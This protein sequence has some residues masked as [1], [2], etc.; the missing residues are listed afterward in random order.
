MR[1]FVTGA[2]DEVLAFAR[3]FGVTVEPAEPGDMMPHNLRTA[4]LDAEGR[5]VKTYSGT[6]WTPAE[7]VADLTAAPA[8]AH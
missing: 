6:T 8:S 5:L 1:H 4:I 3:R 7:L 2:P